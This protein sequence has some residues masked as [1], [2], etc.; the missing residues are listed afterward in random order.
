MNYIL[1]INYYPEDAHIL[2]EK[3]KNKYNDKLDNDDFF[4][5]KIMRV[6]FLCSQRIFHSLEININGNNIKYEPLRGTTN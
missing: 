4:S 6:M 3:I 2:L 1:D 5:I